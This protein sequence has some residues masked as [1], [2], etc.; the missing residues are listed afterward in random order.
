[1]LIPNTALLFETM[2][3]YITGD[4]T[5]SNYVAILQPFMIYVRDLTSKQYNLIVSIIEQHVLDYRKK[6]VQSAKEYAALSTA[7]YAARYAGVSAVYNLLKDSKQMNF[8]TDILELYGLSP[9]NY[10]NI[11]DK[12]VNVPVAMP[13][14]LEVMQVVLD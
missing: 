12:Q 7:K 4:I 1:M 5:L 13:W 9:E 2:N 6:I 14:G 11:G 10:M 3:K 8:D